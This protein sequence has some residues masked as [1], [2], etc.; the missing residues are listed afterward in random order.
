MALKKKILTVIE[1]LLCIRYSTQELKY[2]Y[3][4][5]SHNIIVSSTYYF[6]L[7]FTD[8]EMQAKKGLATWSNNEKMVVSVCRPRTT[9]ILKKLCGNEINGFK[10]DILEIKVCLNLNLF[11]TY[12]YVFY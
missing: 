6:Y 5:N 4:F 8:V 9:L 1:Y 12:A 3:T 10:F 11:F 7:H 2:I